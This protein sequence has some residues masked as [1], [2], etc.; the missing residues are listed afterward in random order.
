MLCDICQK[1][2]ATVHLTEIINGKVM[3]LHLCDECAKAK[4][5]ELKHQLSLTDFLSGLFDKKSL[6]EKKSAVCPG[7]GLTFA[8]FKK[9]GRL[10]CSKCYEVFRD[11]LVPLLRKIHGSVHHAGKG[12]CF[13]QK[14][15]SQEQ[16]IAELKERLNRAVLLE[17]YEEA[18]R[19]RDRIRNLEKKDE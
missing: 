18:A 13:Q 8:E 3:E 17:E 11:Q 1:K 9:S 5:E 7:C 15:V 10:G 12:P 16:I 19:I 14:N 2:N 4:S 6:R